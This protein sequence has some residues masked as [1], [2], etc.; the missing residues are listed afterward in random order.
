MINAAFVVESF[1]EGTRTDAVRLA[2]MLEK[3]TVLVTVDASG[4]L[5]ASVYLEV[6]GRAATWVSWRWPRPI[7]EPGWDV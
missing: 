5:V 7:R 3:G 4:E 6:R 1:L 2:A